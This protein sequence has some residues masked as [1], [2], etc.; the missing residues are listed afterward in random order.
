V[1]HVS[2]LIW[3]SAVCAELS[4]FFCSP[5]GIGHNQN[6]LFVT[7]LDTKCARSLSEAASHEDLELIKKRLR[8]GLRGLSYF[9]VIE[10]AYFTNLQAGV[11]FSGK[12]CVFWHAH[13]LVWGIEQRKLRKH[14]RSLEQAG[15]YLAIA[16]GLKGTKVKKVRQGTLPRLVGYLLK[17]PSKAYRV[18]RQADLVGPNGEPLTN[19][20]GEVLARFVQK[21]C[22]LRPGEHIRLFK[23][24]R[25]L[26]L[27]GLAFASGE[28]APFLAKAKF[29]ALR[30]F[31]ARSS[32]TRTRRLPSKKSAR[33]TRVVERG[34]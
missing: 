20:D 10:P 17:P 21:K 18:R 9:A 5:G 14:L 30:Q 24:M 15:R 4:A 25:P 8:Y 34:Q 27:D 19:Q 16:R 12:K 31:R 23:I 3:G 26:Y 33:R 2:R 32:R 29:A 11:R 13:A 7:L 6:L 1:N 22:D 28:G